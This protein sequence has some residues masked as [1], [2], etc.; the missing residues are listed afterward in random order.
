MD[1]EKTAIPSK[2]EVITLLTTV[3][4]NRTFSTQTIGGLLGMKQVDSWLPKTQNEPKWG[5]EGLKQFFKDNGIHY[6]YTLKETLKAL[7]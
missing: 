7:K 1:S 4:N 3:L 2:E 5:Y 6:S